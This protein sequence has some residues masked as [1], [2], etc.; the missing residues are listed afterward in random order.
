[1]YSLLIVDDEPLTREYMK[2]NVSSIHKSWM[3]AGEASDGA[4]ALEFIEKQSVDL[5][6]TDIKMPVMDGLELCKSISL[7][8]PGQKIVILS[9][10]DEFS[11][12]KEAMLY[13]VHEYLLKPI[14]KEDL[15]ATLDNIAKK[16][17]REKNS[18]LAYK[19]LLKLSIDSKEYIVKKFLQSLVNESVVEIKTLYP[20]I[21]RMKVNLLEG[22]GI[23]MILKL[24]EEMLLV[25]DYPANDIPIYKYILNQCVIEMLEGNN[26]GQTFLDCN[27]NTCVLFTGEDMETVL[28]SCINLADKA[29]SFIHA[30]TGLTITAGIGCPVNDILQLSLSYKTADKLLICSFIPC[31]NHVY[32]YNDQDIAWKI[33]QADETISALTKLKYSFMD[34]SEIDCFISLSKL[35]DLIDCNDM[36]SVLR[37]GMY[38]IK[39]LSAL[40]PECTPELT[41]SAV[42][43]LKSFY[44]RC[45]SCLSKEIVLKLYKEIILCLS[46]RRESNSNILNAG[47]INEESIVEKAKE[48]ICHHYPE[49]I[50]L[51]LIAENVGVSSGYLSQLFHKIAGES[52]IQFLTKVRMEQA[53]KLLKA[54]PDEKLASICEKVGYMG[55]KH[56]SYAFKQYF[57]MTPGDYRNNR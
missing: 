40:K 45:K 52:Y 7:K 50:S 55:V 33:K 14:V 28:K 24:D 46:G 32:A 6:I 54:Y 34:S 43:L 48:Y 51:A 18:E 49:P 1:M 41:E 15:R 36:Q 13:G 25:K 47:V 53:A 10:Y 20:L 56:F 11:Y 27:E 35:I 4:E 30:N 31:K 22:E 57:N 12:A 42:K 39:S 16:I 29:Y 38:I 23:V 5:I 9:G 8:Y 3:V 19:S 2:L 21:Y 44:T 26:T 37:C 17:E